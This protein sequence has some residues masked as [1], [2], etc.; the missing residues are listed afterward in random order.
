MLQRN[1]LV[2]PVD[3]A[4]SEEFGQ[5]LPVEELR[6][7]QSALNA[8]TSDEGDEWLDE[9]IPIGY[10]TEITEEEFINRYFGEDAQ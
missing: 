6:E 7:L 5:R 4:F 10:V 3:V 9:E 8:N 2:Q 1:H